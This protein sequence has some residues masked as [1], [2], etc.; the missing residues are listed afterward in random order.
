MDEISK[1]ALTILSRYTNP[2]QAAL[3]RE[4]GPQAVQIG[5]TIYSLVLQQ[6]QQLDPRTAQ[7][8]PTNPQGYSGPL[9]DILKELVAANKEF[10]NQLTSLIVH[11]EAEVQAHRAA[12]G[13]GA[14]Q[15]GSG[16]VTQN[17]TLSAGERGVVGS[18]ARGNIITGDKNVIGNTSVKDST[19]VGIGS[20]QVAVTQGVSGKELAQVFAP[21]YH[22]IEAKADL[23]PQDKADLRTEVDEIKAAVE[24]KTDPAEIDDSFL[25]RRLRNIQRMA[26]DIIEV[27][28]TTVVNPAAG[29]GL[30]GAK[31][32]ARAKEVQAA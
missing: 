26:P 28:A 14:T 27:I 8:Y 29:L 10:M 4:V 16:V 22:Q 20:G 19:G 2:D 30:V 1:K 15:S 3:G 5:Q 7:H 9:E 32:A 23:S 17:S 31:I 12:T 24:G 25:A 18:S 11:Y 13:T 21:I 6:V